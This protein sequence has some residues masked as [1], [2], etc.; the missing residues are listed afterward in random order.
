MCYI[1]VD[2][3]SPRLKLHCLSISVV[4]PFP[5]CTIEEHLEDAVFIQAPIL[6]WSLHCVIVCIGKSAV[7]KCFLAKMLQYVS[8]SQIV[9]SDIHSTNTALRVYFIIPP[10]L[11]AENTKL[12]QKCDLEKRMPRGSHKDQQ[13]SKSL[14]CLLALLWLHFPSKLTNVICFC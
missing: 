8:S 2:P 3:P 1:P 14:L 11:S 10:V 12:R 13:K 6:S 5:H 7:N 4:S 9:T